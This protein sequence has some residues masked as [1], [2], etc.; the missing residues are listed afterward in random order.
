M[1]DTSRT[2]RALWLTVVLLIGVSVWLRTTD[3]G[4]LPGINGD[5]A[6]Y[7][8][9]AE[10][11]LSG[12]P[13]WQTASGNPLNPF[14]TGPVAVL[15]LVFEPA[16]W[17]LRA[18]S[19]M[20][21]VA[22]V[23]LLFFLLRPVLGATVAA[24]I[25]LLA[26]VLPANVAYSRFGWDPSQVPLAAALVCG[27]SLGR[28]WRL[29]F[30]SALVAVWVHPTAV[31]LVPIAGAVA[32]SEIWRQS[33]DRH[34][35]IRRL[36]LVTAGAVVLAGLLCWAVPATARF[37]PSQIFSRMFDPA[38]ALEFATLVPPL[39]SGT[40]V[41]RYVVGEPSAMSVAV[42]DAV[43]WTLMILAGAGLLIGWRRLDARLRAFVI[44]T[45]AAWWCFYLVL[46]TGGVRPHVDRYA[47]WSIV[48]VLI[49]VGVGLGE[50]A[51]RASQRRIVTLGL[52]AVSIA[53]LMSFQTGYLDVLRD[54]GGHSHRAFRTSYVEPKRAAL[55][56]IIAAQPDGP[57]RILAEDWW[58]RWPIQYLAVRDPRIHVGELS[59]RP[60]GIDRWSDVVQ[61]G[62][63]VV[64]FAGSPLAP[65]LDARAGAV[66]E[67]TIE[68]PDGRAILYVYRKT[69]RP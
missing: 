44:G 42:H 69:S 24:W 64:V 10:R 58:S 43:V 40:T 17:I 18:P 22:L 2:D 46:G 16:F 4:R 41:Y 39:F 52:C 5:E 63:H 33:P 9:Q 50:L 23:P 29:A 68:G 21:G 12:D 27:A 47:L 19:W 36:G 13:V 11:W 25:A 48:P 54:S 31:F 14:H 8:V 7:G 61:A 30:S 65:L 3:L 56:A 66:R 35:R 60:Y 57:V 62:D 26:A 55:D 59:T 32:A 20:A 15:Q 1:S 45:V 51:H 38:Q 53:A 37:S 34:H 28:R 6:W 67:A 49:C